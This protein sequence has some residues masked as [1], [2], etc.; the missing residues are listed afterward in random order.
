MEIVGCDPAARPAAAALG[1]LLRALA[2]PSNGATS[3]LLQLRNRSLPDQG[4]LALQWAASPGAG[5][6]AFLD[7][8]ACL[9]GIAPGWS[10]GPLSWLWDERESQQSG[11]DATTRAAWDAL[12]PAL[13]RACT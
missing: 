7:V 12:Q 1:A 9:A 6:P 5:D 11:F 2:W 10:G 8:A 3:A 4:R 13:E